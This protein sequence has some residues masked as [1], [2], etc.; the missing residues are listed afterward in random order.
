MIRIAGGIAP[1]KTAQQVGAHRRQQIVAVESAP[2]L[3]CVDQIR[4]HAAGPSTIATAAAWL[5]SITGDGLIR[6][7]TS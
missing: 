3:Q 1:A 7:R 6:S 4:G 5:S 2:R